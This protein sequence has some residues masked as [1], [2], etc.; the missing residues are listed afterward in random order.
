MLWEYW[1]VTSPQGCPFFNDTY[2]EQL[3]NGYNTLRFDVP[4]NHP[5]ASLLEEEGF[6]IYTKDEGH[7]LFRIKEIYESHGDQMLKTIA[8]EPSATQDLMDKVMRPA[9]YPSQTLTMVVK[10]IL[11]LTGWEL[12]E[13]FYDGIITAEF[14]DYPT[15]LEA[16][17]SVIAQFDVEIEFKVEFDGLKIDKKIIN[18]YEKRGEETKK[19]MEYGGNLLGLTR[20]INTNQLRTAMIAVGKDDGD[21]NKITIAGLD[22]TVPEPYAIVGDTII[23][24]NALEKWCPDGNHREG[25]FKDDNAQSPLEL[26]KNTLAEL[27]K[28]NKPQTTYDVSVAMLEQLTGYEFMKISIGDTIRVKD[29]TFAPPL[30]LDARVLEKETS[31]TENDKGRIVLG[32]FVL[33]KVKPITAVQ[34]MQRKIMFFEDDWNRALK[35]AE[36]AKQKAEEIEDNVV[37]KTEIYSTKGNTFKNGAVDTILM[38]VVYKGKDNITDTLPASAFIWRKKDKNGVIDTAWGNANMGVGKS[39]AISS[40]QVASRATFECDIDIA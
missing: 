25:V 28:Y 3:L 2:N 11:A 6:V 35:E 16:L 24:E 17:H 30:Y 18:L 31:L 20:N 39:V 33:L 4:S 32:E 29:T 36:E 1:T 26:Y 8:C 19:I 10:A 15:A 21:G 13:S 37:Y 7:E 38:A 12:G 5:T 27:K 14:N 9:I 22:I 40:A 23:D 34:Q